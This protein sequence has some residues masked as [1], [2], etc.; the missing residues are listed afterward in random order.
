MQIKEDASRGVVN[1]TM[2]LLWFFVLLIVAAVMMNTGGVTL[3]VHNGTGIPEVNRTLV[4]DVRA[5]P[6]HA[7]A[8]N[9]LGNQVDIDHCCATVN[10]AHVGCVLA[11]VIAITPASARPPWLAVISE[12]EGFIIAP[13]TGPPKPSA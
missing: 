1:S 10:C 8:A 5:E 12:G 6:D 3:G 9:S 13:E 11:T 4:A 7:C 2:R